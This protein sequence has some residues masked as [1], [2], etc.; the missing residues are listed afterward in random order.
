MYN[1][2]I[3]RAKENLKVK[4]DT[5][6]RYVVRTH[7]FYNKYY[8][9]HKIINIIVRIIG[10]IRNE[11]TLHQDDNTMLGKAGTRSTV[12]S[13][14]P[15]QNIRPGDQWPSSVTRLYATSSGKQVDS[16]TWLESRQ[17]HDPTLVPRPWPGRTRMPASCRASAA[18]VA[19]SSTPSPLRVRKVARD[20]T[21]P[22]ASFSGRR[23]PPAVRS[24]VL[25]ER[26]R[27]RGSAD[28][29]SPVSAH[30]S[31]DQA[32]LVAADWNSARRRTKPDRLTDVQVQL[33]RNSPQRR[34]SVVFRTRQAVAWSWDWARWV[35]VYAW[36]SRVPR[37]GWGD[38]RRWGRR[39]RWWL[40]DWCRRGSESEP[41][42][43]THEYSLHINVIASQI[44]CTVM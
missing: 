21:A 34:R 42:H 26:W 25:P 22:S 20:R 40:N 38:R 27:Y 15:P 7:K 35:V 19:K 28:K 16:G 37:Q 23:F 36:G 2:Q 8:Y 3:W 41:C 29:M 5:K 30:Q 10:S 9:W 43:R 14:D 1:E 6:H 17:L 11:A 24:A 44:E 31:Q 33:Y 18:A 39:C 12:L 13:L 32:P 4:I